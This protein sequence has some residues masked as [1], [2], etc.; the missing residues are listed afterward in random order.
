MLTLG[1]TVISF[2]IRWSESYRDSIYNDLVHNLLKSSQAIAT[3]HGTLHDF[4]Y[5]NYA[6]QGQPVHRILDRKGMLEPLK[7]TLTAYDPDGFLQRRLQQ[8]F[9]LQNCSSHTI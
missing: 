5:A 4:V 8:P 7:E 1:E 6:A 9:P 3:Q 2:E